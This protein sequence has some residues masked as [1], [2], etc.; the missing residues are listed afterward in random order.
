MGS[1]GEELQALRTRAED[2]A[3][4]ESEVKEAAASASRLEGLYQAEQASVTLS[5]KAAWKHSKNPVRLGQ[6]VGRS[7]CDPLY[8]TLSDIAHRLISFRM[9][10]PSGDCGCLLCVPLFR[11]DIASL[12]MLRIRSPCGDSDHRRTLRR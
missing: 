7:P 1:M 9:E 3:R 11:C 2:A 10:P 6:V 12:F 4:L 5:L 8:V